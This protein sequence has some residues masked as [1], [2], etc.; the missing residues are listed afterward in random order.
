MPTNQKTVGFSSLE[1]SAAVQELCEAGLDFDYAAD[2]VKLASMSEEDK[3]TLKTTALST[4][5]ALPADV[6]GAALGLHLGNKYLK[7][8][9]MKAPGFLQKV[10]VPP[11]INL[12]GGS[13]GQFV[14]TG[15]AG[16]LAG[17]AATKYSL[18]GKIKES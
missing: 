7:D 4:A 6:A 8:V 10:K 11:H 1:K 5:A 14:G 17:L 16:G 13:I 12:S 3:A 2:L 9:S 15:I 18:H